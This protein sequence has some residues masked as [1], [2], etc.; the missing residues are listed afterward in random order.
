MLVLPGIGLFLFSTDNLTIVSTLYCAGNNNSRMQ[1]RVP[2][3]LAAM[4]SMLVR[5]QNDK[6][7]G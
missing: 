6:S 2:I 5:F 7:L 3:K 1:F 4:M